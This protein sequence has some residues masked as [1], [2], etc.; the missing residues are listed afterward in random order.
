MKRYIRHTIAFMAL[1]LCTLAPLWAE[2][3]EYQSPRMEVIQADRDGNFQPLT[4]MVAEFGN[5]LDRVYLNNDFS[6]RKTDIVSGLDEIYLWSECGAAIDAL[7]IA[8][9]PTLQVNDTKCQK[10]GT[11]N[12]FPEIC[13]LQPRHISYDNGGDPGPDVNSIVLMKFYFR[14]T[15]YKGFQDFYQYKIPF[16]IWDQYLASLK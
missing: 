16:G 14:P 12:I 6:P 8:Y 9:K 7:R 2:N 11:N 1:F 13:N 5:T 15:S 3:E 10:N 4:D